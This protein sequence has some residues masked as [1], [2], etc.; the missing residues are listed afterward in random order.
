MK[1]SI[2]EQKQ[3][4]HENVSITFKTVTIWAKADKNEKVKWSDIIIN[5]RR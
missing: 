3:C 4:K 2:C 1:C 5:I